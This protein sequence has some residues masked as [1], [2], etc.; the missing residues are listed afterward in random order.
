[1]K[2]TIITK[3]KETRT[4]FLVPP[5]SSRAASLFQDHEHQRSMHIV[6]HITTPPTMRKNETYFVPKRK[7][8]MVDDEN[9]HVFILPT[10]QRPE[11]EEALAW[12][13]SWIGDGDELSIL[14]PP[15]PPPYFAGDI[16]G[17]VSK[18]GTT[19][20]G[21]TTDE[22]EVSTIP[23]YEGKKPC[24]SFLRSMI[25]GPKL[26]G[27]LPQLSRPNLHPLVRPP[28]RQI[29]RISNLPPRSTIG[30]IIRA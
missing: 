1:M 4:R 2:L 14:P 7:R 26:S 17:C 22:T 11:P 19:V 16:V 24:F 12:G 18:E 9:R 10:R 6:I 20:G 13:V 23:H 15:V 29:N 8:R 28:R 3:I 21:G 5:S 25:F 27:V 30:R